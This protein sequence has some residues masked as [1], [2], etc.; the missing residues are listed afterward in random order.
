MDLRPCQAE[1]VSYMILGTL[2]HVSHFFFSCEMGWCFTLE[3]NLG[4]S[5]SVVGGIS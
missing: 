4:L 5:C 1:V 3:G 2:L